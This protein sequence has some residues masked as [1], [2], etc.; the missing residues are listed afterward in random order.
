MLIS[1]MILATMV[2]SVTTLLFV[3]SHGNTESADQASANRQIQAQI[4][5]L[6]AASYASLADGTYA[7]TTSNINRV[8]T[9]QY[10]ISDYTDGSGAHTELKQVVATI[11]WYEGKVLKTA[12]ASTYIGQ[13]GINQQ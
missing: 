3:A 13:H 2:L 4:E 6:R 9:A 12:T 11:T 5:Q 1:L 10:V 8:Q 7:F